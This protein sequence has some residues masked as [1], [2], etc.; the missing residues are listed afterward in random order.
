MDHSEMFDF[1]KIKSI[2]SYDRNL[3]FGYFRILQNLFNSLDPYYNAPKLVIYLCLYYY[4][5]REFFA[6]HG[7]FIKLDKTNKL[8][9]H[10]K[11]FKIFEIESTNT[12]YGNIDINPS[13]KSSNLYIWRFEIIESHYSIYIGIDAS[14]KSYK[15]SSFYD[16]SSFYFASDGEI[17]LCHDDSLIDDDTI[18]NFGLIDDSDYWQKCD[19]IKMELNTKN[20][21]IKYYK[22]WENEG[23]GF[24]NIDFGNKIC[25]LAISIGDEES[26]KLIDFEQKFIQ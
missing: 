3:I 7:L 19:L 2:P 18:D 14:N 6:V 17:L 21:T 16:K 13:D 5:D 15:D 8:A 23:I 26:I 12:I 11:K 4:D 25:N 10:T 20:K 1:R 24:K 22:N 9:S